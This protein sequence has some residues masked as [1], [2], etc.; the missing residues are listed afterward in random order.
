MENANKR[1]RIS[2]LFLSL[3]PVPK[4]S[5]PVKFAHI[6]HFQWTGINETKIE[7]TWIHFKSDVFA[8][9]AVVDAKAPYCREKIADRLATV[10]IVKRFVLCNVLP[11]GRFG[12]FEKGYAPGLLCDGTFHVIPCFDTLYRDRVC[13][14]FLPRYLCNQQPIWKRFLGSV[15]STN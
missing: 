2:F 13:W 15:N 4:K 7:K 6:S 10:K 12:K 11:K 3:S 5:T 8:A 1:R 14:M 9:V